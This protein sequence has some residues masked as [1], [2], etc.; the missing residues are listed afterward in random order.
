MENVHSV[1]GQ[2]FGATIRAINGDLECNGRNADQVNSRVGY[3]IE[4]CKQFGVQTGPNLR[5]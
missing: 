4:Y 2:G 3:Y 1:V 5:C